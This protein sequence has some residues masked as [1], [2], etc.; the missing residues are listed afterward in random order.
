MPKASVVE[1]LRQAINV[2]PFIGQLLVQRALETFEEAQSFFSPSISQLHDPFLM[3]DLAKATDRIN[4]AIENQE[5]I[6]V[7]GDYDVDGTSSVAMMYR[8]LSRFNENVDCYIPDRYTEGYGVSM[9]GMNY[10]VDN[11]FDLLI[12]LDCGIK[13]VEEL[14]WAQEKVLK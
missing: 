14:G 3:A 7:Y 13:A 11:S 6:L 8:Y 2:R 4:R 9:Q 1:S 5:R 12:T 10:A